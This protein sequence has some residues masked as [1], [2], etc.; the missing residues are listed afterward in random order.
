MKAIETRELTKFYGKHRGIE[1]ASLSVEEGEFFGFIGPNGAGKSTT[2]RTLLGLIK[3]TS[4]S[5]SVLGRDCVRERLSVLRDTGYLPAE[6]GFYSGSRVGD[7]IEYSAKLRGIDCR[8]EAALLCGELKLDVKRRVSEL[9]L[10]GRKK[11]SIVCAMQHKPKLLILDEPTSGLDPLMQRVFFELLSRRHETGGTIFFSSHILSEVQR[12]CR[13]AA[14]IREGR[15]IACD[16]LKSLTK[17]SAKKVSFT[18]NADVTGLEGVSD[19]SVTRGRSA[20]MYSGDINRLLAALSRGDIS[21][22]T[23]EEPSLEEVFMRYYEEA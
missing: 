1:N 22:L 13:R 17:G 14:V 7:I 19:F 2:I 11:L 16:E 8:A 21:D 15:V 12:S 6:S 4:G 10:G 5:G 3:P 18:G 23:L 9:S 20:F